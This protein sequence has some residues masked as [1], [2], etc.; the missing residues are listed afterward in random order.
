MSIEGFSNKRVP[1]SSSPIPGKVDSSFGLDLGGVNSVSKSVMIQKSEIDMVSKGLAEI[2]F[3][4]GDTN[5][6]ESFSAMLAE[7][8]IEAIKKVKRRQKER[9]QG[10]QGS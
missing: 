10:R 9:R 2:A 6:P 5:D 1:G 4:L 8:I 3:S 7:D